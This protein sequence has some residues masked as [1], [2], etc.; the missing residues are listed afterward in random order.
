MLQYIDKGPRTCRV[1]KV[2]PSSVC[3]KASLKSHLYAVMR[4]RVPGAAVV[5]GA[6]RGGRGLPQQG[7]PFPLPVALSVP[8]GL[9]PWDYFPLLLFFLQVSLTFYF[10]QSR[11]AITADS[12]SL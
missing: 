6:C 1:Q 3:R 11:V 7:A 9:I 4:P 5:G 10:A 2:G 12:A 8:F